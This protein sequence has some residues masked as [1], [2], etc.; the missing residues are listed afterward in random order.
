MRL[1]EGQALNDRWACA[2][3]QCSSAPRLWHLWRILSTLLSRVLAFRGLH[4]DVR[5]LHLP[6]HLHRHPRHSSRFDSHQ[7]D[8]LTA[9]AFLM[10]KP[11]H[12][13]SQS[14]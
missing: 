3:P 9:L 5:S 11:S 14:G 6:R 7:N 1:I 10:D 4:R 12:Q 13:Q 2:V 8:E